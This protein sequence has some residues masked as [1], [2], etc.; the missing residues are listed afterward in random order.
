[1]YT[2]AVSAFEYISVFKLLTE[3]KKQNCCIK[4]IKDVHKLWITFLN[5][6]NTLNNNRVVIEIILRF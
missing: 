1:M 4:Q 3:K 5:S 2:T 6:K